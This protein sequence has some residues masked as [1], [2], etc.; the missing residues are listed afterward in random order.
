MDG[1]RAQSWKYVTF[2]FLLPAADTQQEETGQ[3]QMRQR[4]GLQMLQSLC[5]IQTAGNR[6]RE[7]RAM[8]P[9]MN[10]AELSCEL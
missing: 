6:P 1:P 7:F 2:I 3:N 4:R 8:M 10:D 5:G 9:V